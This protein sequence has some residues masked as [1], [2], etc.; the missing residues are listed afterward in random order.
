MT[1]GALVSEA[2]L[3]RPN[4]DIFVLISEGEGKQSPKMAVVVV[5]QLVEWSLSVPEN[6]GSNLVIGK[7]YIL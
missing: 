7:F 1:F 4:D 2:T 6:R 5:A 3:P